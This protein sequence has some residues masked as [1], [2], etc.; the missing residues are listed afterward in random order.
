MLFTRGLYLLVFVPF[1]PSSLL[2]SLTVYQIRD[3]PTFL[4]E[5]AQS[6]RPGGVLLLGDGEM[7]LYDEDQRPMSYADSTSS[8]IQRIFFASYNAMKTRGGSIDSPSMSPTWLRDINSLTDVGWAKVFIP[9]GPWIY[10]KP[11]VTS[12]DVYYLTRSYRQRERQSA[13]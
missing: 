4:D 3:F 12:I 6:L 2:L 8:W 7:Q 9:I 1:L 10:S 5:L 11:L 13:C